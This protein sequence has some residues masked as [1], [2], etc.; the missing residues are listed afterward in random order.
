MSC[1]VKSCMFVGNK[2]IIL[3]APIHCRWSKQCYAKFLNFWWKNKPIY[4]LDG[5]RVS[6]TN[7]I[8]FDKAIVRPFVHHFM[9]TDL[10]LG[11][12][13]HET[14]DSILFK[15]SDLHNLVFSHELRSLVFSV[16]SPLDGSRIAQTAWFHIPSVCENKNTKTKRT[17]PTKTSHDCTISPSFLSLP[18]VRWS[19]LNTSSRFTFFRSS[20]LCTSV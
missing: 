20:A 8:S 4:I 18:R 14:Q 1:E 9:P 16:C 5:L 3:T 7:Q 10:Y 13:W 12:V 6:N 2:S 17:H 19:R 15:D 11:Y